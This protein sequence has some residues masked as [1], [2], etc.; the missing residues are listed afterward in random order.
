MTTNQTGVGDK[1]NTKLNFGTKVFDINNKYDSTNS[2]WTPVAG[3][4]VLGAGV[5]IPS[6]VAKNTLPQVMVYKNGSVLVQNGAQTAGN[7]A[8]AQVSVVDQASGTDYYECWC[9][10]DAGGTTSTIEAVNFIT[11]FWGA[12]L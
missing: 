9:N 8:N 6:G 1:V 7:R 12:V 10:I 11:T 2:R 3:V 4:V 5:S